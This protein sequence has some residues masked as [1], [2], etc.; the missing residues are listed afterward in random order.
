MKALNH[1]IF[2]WEMFVTDGWIRMKYIEGIL[3]R[4]FIKTRDIPLLFLSSDKLDVN[5]GKN[6]IKECLTHFFSTTS[7]NSWYVLSVQYY[8]I[9]CTLHLAL[10]KCYPEG[11]YIVQSWWFLYHIFGVYV[12]L[13]SIILPYLNWML[14][15]QKH[16][17]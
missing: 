14:A 8:Q 2:E 10:L 7:Q 12:L 6:R 1:N 16:C 15:S 17:H 4:R 5:C 9:W 13:L 3:E 11:F